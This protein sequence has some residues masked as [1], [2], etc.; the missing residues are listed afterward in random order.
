MVAVWLGAPLAGVSVGGEGEGE[1]G[2]GSAS[3]TGKAL[4]DGTSCSDEIIGCAESSIGYAGLREPGVCDDSGANLRCQ[5][6][7]TASTADFRPR[8]IRRRQFRSLGHGNHCRL[9]RQ[10]RRRQ[11]PL[12]S[13]SRIA[14]RQTVGD[15]L[16]IS[17]REPRR[18]SRA[19]RAGHR[20]RL[21]R[22]RARRN[23]ARR[24][25][26]A[27]RSSGARFL[28]ADFWYRHMDVH[29]HRREDPATR[30]MKLMRPLRQR[31]ACL[32]LDCAP[33]MSLVSENVM[34]AA[35]ASW[36]R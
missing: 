16:S 18:L 13:T 3:F 14:P 35:D 7:Q 2:D 24:L 27:D 6:V 8:I 25:R 12:R 32:I 10:R 22:S 23:G 20:R 30:L 1:D 33:G 4:T 29:L 36:F 9:Q 21:E 11:R 15:A 28:S 19:P 34:H 5:R 26:D 17:T 31:Y